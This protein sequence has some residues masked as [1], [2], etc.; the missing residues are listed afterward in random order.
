MGV[1][2]VPKS[3]RISRSDFF[4]LNVILEGQRLLFA[5]W[6]GGFFFFFLLS[7]AKFTETG[8]MI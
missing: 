6:F 1:Y 8:V 3:A 4:F 7:K 2:P 5:F